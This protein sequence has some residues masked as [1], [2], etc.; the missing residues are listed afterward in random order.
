VSPRDLP[1]FSGLGFTST[2]QP[3][4]TEFYVNTGDEIQ[5][6]MLAWQA[7]YPLSHLPSSK[8]DAAAKNDPRYKYYCGVSLCPACSPR[9]TAAELEFI[10]SMLATTGFPLPLN[11]NTM[12]FF[13][14]VFCFFFFFGFFVFFWFFPQL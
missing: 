12:V 11:N 9:N 3:A 5:V 7:L 8:T 4:Y 2:D 6:L 1:V 14:L 13:F 10:L